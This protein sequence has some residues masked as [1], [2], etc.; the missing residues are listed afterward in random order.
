MCCE[1]AKQWNWCES[2][3]Q[4]ENQDWPHGRGGVWAKPR[5]MSRILKGK[6]KAEALQALGGKALWYKS[7]CIYTHNPRNRGQNLH[8]VTWWDMEVEGKDKTIKEGLACDA[9]R[10]AS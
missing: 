10:R 3:G 4:G 8:G 1:N 2:E 5:R 9:G 6:G 7:M